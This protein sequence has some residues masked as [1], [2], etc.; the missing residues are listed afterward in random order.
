MCG[1]ARAV[2]DRVLVVRLS[3]MGD[4]IH[5]MPAMAGKNLAEA[6]GRSSGEVALPLKC[7]LGEPTTLMRRAALFIGEDSGS[8]QLA[9]ASPVPVIALLGPAN[10]ER[11]GPFG[12]HSVVLGRPESVSNPSHTDHPNEGLIWIDPQPVIAA[13]DQLLGEH[14]G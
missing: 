2:P 8:L 3:T 14:R 4:S 10:P 12:T 9:A 13:A 1:V 5:S 7:S 11:N 6:V